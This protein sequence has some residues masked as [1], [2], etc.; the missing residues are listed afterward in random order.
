VRYNL[1]KKFSVA[2]TITIN[3]IKYLVTKDGEIIF[4][5]FDNDGDTYIY[6]DEINGK[7]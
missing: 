1:A 4:K 2:D 5:A 6:E 3:D 7:R